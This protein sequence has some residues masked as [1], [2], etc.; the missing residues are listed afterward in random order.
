MT[1]RIAGLEPQWGQW[2]ETTIPWER[3]DGNHEPCLYMMV[4]PRHL[5][6][7]CCED[8]PF[9]PA[10]SDTFPPEPMC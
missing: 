10:G 4:D 6:D 7:E 5:V 1:D 3:L 9:F 2:F 8:L